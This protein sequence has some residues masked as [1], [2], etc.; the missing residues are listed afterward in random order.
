MRKTCVS[1]RI[2][3]LEY[4]AVFWDAATCAAAHVSP[5]DAARE[6]SAVLQRHTDSFYSVQ[7]RRRRFRVSMPD[8][9]LH[10]SAW[11]P[12]ASSYAA[13]TSLYRSE[14]KWQAK[15][16]CY[17]ECVIIQLESTGGNWHCQRSFLAEGKTSSHERRQVSLIAQKE[18]IPYSWGWINALQNAL[19]G[20][21]LEG[22]SAQ[23]I[24]QKLIDGVNPL[25][26]KD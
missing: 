10:T 23:C 26:V 21:V 6:D 1:S 25:T 3:M 11:S 7:R 5:E 22:E 18:V 15:S 20:G 16:N 17:T 14:I 9:R 8:E 19:P 2:A 4:F 24:S 12:Q 13:V